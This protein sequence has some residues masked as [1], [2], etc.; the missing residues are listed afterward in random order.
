M[1][2]DVFPQTSQVH[3]VMLMACSVC[4]ITSGGVRNLH[5]TSFHYVVA[6]AGKCD[7]HFPSNACDHIHHLTCHIYISMLLRCF[8]APS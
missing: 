8:V 5:L 6:A 4:G 7:Y 2:E 1:R 3:S